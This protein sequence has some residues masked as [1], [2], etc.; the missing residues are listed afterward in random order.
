MVQQ[1]S[2]LALT[3][4]QQ[5]Q[6]KQICNSSSR[7]SKALFCLWPLWGASTHVVHKQTLKTNT[8]THNT[9]NNLW[10][11]SLITMETFASYLQY[12]SS[13]EFIV[14]LSN[15][16]QYTYKILTINRN[17]SRSRHDGTHLLSKGGNGR[18]MLN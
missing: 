15:M 8:S 17:N 11:I 13:Q 3:Q 18:W 14:V 12:F 4:V 5:L 6:L 10:K 1:Q 2:T 16:F 9:K 7:G